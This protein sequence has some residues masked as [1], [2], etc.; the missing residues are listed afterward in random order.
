MTDKTIVIENPSDPIIQAIFLKPHLRL[1]SL[2]MTHSRLRQSD[3]LAA[4]TA[5]TGKPYKRGKPGLEAALNDVIEMI[6][7]ANAK[8]VN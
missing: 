1:M 8:K 3:V 5:L 2:G 4:A 6:N 7:A